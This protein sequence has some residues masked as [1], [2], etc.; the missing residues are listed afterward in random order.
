MLNIENLI[1]CDMKRDKTSFLPNKLAISM[2]KNNL[3]I[4]SLD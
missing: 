3:M 4:R 1:G 2:I